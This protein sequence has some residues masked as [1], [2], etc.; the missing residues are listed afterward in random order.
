MKK[1]I[2]GLWCCMVISVFCAGSADATFQGSKVFKQTYPDQPSPYYSC[3]ICHTSKVGKKG[4]ENLNPYGKSLEWV[5]PEELTVEQLKAAESLDPDGDGVSS[6]QEIQSGTLPGDASS[7]PASGGENMT[8]ADS[9]HQW[10]KRASSS[11]PKEAYAAEVETSDPAAATYVGSE[12]CAACH[13]KQYQEFQH[14]THARISIP[15]VVGAEGCEM[16]HGPGSLH[17]EAGG[18]RGVGGMGK[19]DPEGCFQ[20]H[21]EKK[22]QFRLTHHH[23]VLEGKMSCSSCHNAHGEDVRPWSTTSLEGV[24]QACFKCHKE[25]R[26]PFTWEHEALREG[27]TTCHQVHG[28]I[29][30]KMLVFRDSNLC[31]RCHT[32]TNFPRVGLSNHGSR[33]NEGPCFSAGCHTAVHGSNFDDHLRY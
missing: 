11:M 6:G 9:L 29:H 20:C 27:C 12:T 10:A 14:S 19:P 5:M 25:Q 21:L 16:C 8:Q 24:N 23:P 4:I 22:S 7:A 13:E 1:I 15:D 17:V 3:A 2:L 33:L 32:Q 26:G 28:S 30:D 31:L 18:G